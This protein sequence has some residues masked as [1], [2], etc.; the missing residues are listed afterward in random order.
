M[1]SGGY[2]LEQE[3]VLLALVPQCRARAAQGP[4]DTTP[5]EA[6]GRLLVSMGRG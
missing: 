6:L 5:V 1:C 3:M 4:P 2:K